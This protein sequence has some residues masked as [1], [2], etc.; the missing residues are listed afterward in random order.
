MSKGAL[1][2]SIRRWVSLFLIVLTITLFRVT[3][4]PFMPSSNIHQLPPSVIVQSGLIP[5]GFMLFGLLTFGL[6]AIVFVLIQEG[7]SGKRMRKGLMFGFLFGMMW[8][9]YLLEPAP[10]VE[11]LP[12]FEVLVY[13]LADGI[14][15]LS[16]G[17]LLGRFIGND[18]KGNEKVRFS[19]NYA[20]LLAV[21]VLF[22]AGRM[23]SYN[24]FH[25]YSSYAARQF[26]TI[27]WA[28]ATELWIG[29][30]YL[31]L[32]PGI[33][34]KSPLLKAIYFA[35]VIYGIDYFLFNLFMPLVFNYKIWPMGALLSYAD[36]LVRASMDILS[37]VAG[38]YIC[39][40]I[41]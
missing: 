41:K 2:L 38:V 25:I 23:L 29:V 12:F 16:M 17:L 15:I 8:A 28:A 1:N 21:P 7:L 40:K 36:L 30:M 18:S 4:Q 37:V 39:E 10:H 20:T 34:D 31:L 24:V 19:S 9:L 3:L 27:V 33:S 6:L 11:G 32:R 13:P 5:I 14:T 35:V 26:D 22:I